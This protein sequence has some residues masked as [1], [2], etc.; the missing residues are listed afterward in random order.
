MRRPPGPRK[1]GE[2]AWANRQRKRR[3]PRGGRRGRLF[4]GWEEEEGDGH[5]GGGYPRVGRQGISSR[6]GRRGGVSG[7]TYLRS[8][9][10]RLVGQRRCRTGG[11][12][13]WD[14]PGGGGCGWGIGPGW[15]WAPPRTRWGGC[16]GARPHGSPRHPTLKTP[17]EQG[18][19]GG[20]GGC[21]RHPLG[22][23]AQNHLPRGG[24]V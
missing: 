6:G 18:S 12:P 7:G 15:G 20:V 9:A 1:E 5:R 11:A 17:W 3:A 14:T 10:T 13:T 8:A 19:E 4:V 16:R 22:G 2:P 24:A 23:P 21:G